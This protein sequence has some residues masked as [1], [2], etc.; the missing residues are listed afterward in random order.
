MPASRPRLCPPD[1]CPKGKEGVCLR[2]AAACAPCPLP[3]ETVA[4]GDSSGRGQ[5]PA[6]RVL[7]RRVHVSIQPPQV[8]QSRQVVLSFGAAAVAVEPSTYDAIVRKTPGKLKTAKTQGVV[9][10]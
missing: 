2:S 10:T 9:A 1:Y 3:P 6:P 7:P 5:P 8:S 4:H